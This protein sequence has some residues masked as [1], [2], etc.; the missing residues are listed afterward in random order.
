MPSQSLKMMKTAQLYRH[1]EGKMAKQ[2]NDIL[3]AVHPMA[4]HVKPE[5][6]SMVVAKIGSKVKHVGVGD[7]VTSSDLD[8]L[9]DAGHKVK[10]IEEALTPEA[11]SLIQTA[12]GPKVRGNK[13]RKT[14]QS[15]R[16]MVSLAKTNPKNVK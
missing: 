9:S 5:G 7:K 15:A 6:K 1:F 3:E 2:L 12:L 10:E 13:L 11:K 8:D 16:A 4:V 14:S